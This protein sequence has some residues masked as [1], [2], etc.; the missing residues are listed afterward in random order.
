MRE[1]VADFCREA[2]I[3]NS[4]GFSHGFCA[5]RIRPESG[6]RCWARCWNNT[7]RPS[8][9]A[10]AATREVLP[11]RDGRGR[12]ARE[13]SLPVRHSLAFVALFAQN[14]ATSDPRDP[15]FA[16]PHVF[17]DRAT[18]LNLATWHVSP[19]REDARPPGIAPANAAFKVLSGRI[20]AAQ[21]PGLQPWATIYSRF[22]AKSL[23][24]R[25]AT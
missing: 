3:D 11:S 18:K 1:E 22:A 6:T 20:R 17:F 12:T 9:R 25:N 21:N 19:A 13:G 8:R 5:A 14:L 24:D 16:E 7:R 4:P 10:S 15:R 23:R 2:A